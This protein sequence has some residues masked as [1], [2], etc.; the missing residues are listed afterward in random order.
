VAP[1]L[2]I[3]LLR[4]FLLVADRG[5]MTAAS[6]VLQVTQG[7][8]SQQ[9][10][11]LESRLG[12]ALFVRDRRALRLTHDGER[13]LGHARSLLALN[14]QI[15]DEMTGH[16]ITGHI[17]LGAPFDLVGTLLPAPIKSFAA[18]HPEVELSLVCA[19][20]TDL[21]AA[22]EDGKVDLAVVEVPVASPAARHLAVERL[23]WVGARGG[24]AHRIRPLPVSLASETCA[25][26]PLV[27]DA[28]RGHATTWR[29]L[30]ENGTFEA[31]LATVRMD[32]AV[33]ASLA[34]C[35]PA[36]LCVLEPLADLPALPFIGVDIR[37][38]A[39]EAN[40][41]VTELAR[42]IANTLTAVPLATSAPMNR[43]ASSSG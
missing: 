23:V 7:A 4:T 42:R 43:T 21:L 6:N 20:S 1:D 24:T 29:T 27:L 17:R 31:T 8:V 22:V 36:D 11:R 3:A 35:V 10:A 15:W 41:A 40:P 30:F 2:D 37:F 25:F 9:V 16:G 38:P 34:S 18:D 32:L 5:S 28:L 33:T 13:L 12:R 19:S 39:G 14:D 26:R